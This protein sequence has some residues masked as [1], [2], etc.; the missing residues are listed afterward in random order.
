MRIHALILV[1]TLIGCS[2]ETVAQPPPPPVNWSAL[3][4]QPKV[5][6]GADIVSAKERALPEA[7][8]AA[9]ASQGFAQLGP[10]LDDEAHFASPGMDDARGRS[11]VEHA[12]EILLGSFDQR[13]VSLGRVWR[14]PSEQTIEWTMAGTQERDWLGLPPTH[15]AVSFKGLT[16]LWTKDDGSIVDTHVYVDVA[17][18]KAQLG[19]GPKDLLALP[20][21]A[22]ASP[23]PPFEQVGSL[24]E[25]SNVATVRASLEALEKK[26]EAGY[27]AAMTEDVEV[28]TLERPQPVR[29]RDGARAYFKAMHKAIGQLDTTVDSVWGVGRFVV[30]EYSIAGE[31]VGAIGWIPPQRD[32]VVR[33]QVADIAEM[34][35]GKIARLWRYDNPAQ[36]VASRGP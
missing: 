22:T 3:H 32:K 25:K 20:P 10:L 9:L 24:E 30:V 2:S 17:V 5:D 13:R 8:V 14:T 26:D 33:L 4:S 35:D 34:R 11:A 6:A 19:T 29:S 21:P 31:Q 12:H 36:I 28:Y 18:V 16:L 1:G 23:V 27:T 15:K 7:Y